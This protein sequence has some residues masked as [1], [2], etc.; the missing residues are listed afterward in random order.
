MFKEIPVKNIKNYLHFYGW[1]KR[2]GDVVSKYSIYSTSRQSGKE[3]ILHNED[4]KV[5]DAEKDLA[6]TTIAEFE[7][8]PVWVVAGLIYEMWDDSIH[9]TISIRNE[10]IL[11]KII[12]KGGYCYDENGTCPFWETFPE[13]GK[14]SCGYCSY[15]QKGDWMTGG[16]MLL[17]DQCKECGIND[18]ED[19]DEPK[20]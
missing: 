6:I 19:L 16:T 10:K 11:E 2:E 12:P 4:E 3:L 1:Y 9:R 18:S 15:L 7:E 13:M 14:Q 17:W 8:R 20:N 5:N